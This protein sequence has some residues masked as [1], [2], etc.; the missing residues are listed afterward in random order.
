MA[1]GIWICHYHEW[2]SSEPSD[3]H[4]WAFSCT[5]LQKIVRAGLGGFYPSTEGLRRHNILTWLS[6]CSPPPV[7]PA[8]VANSALMT[9]GL[10][11]GLEEIE[12]RKEERG[13]PLPYK[14]ALTSIRKPNKLTGSP[15]LTLVDSCLGSL[16]E[17][18]TPFMSLP[19]KKFSNSHLNRTIRWTQCSSEVM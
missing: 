16:L 12:A 14:E 15:E 8:V 3:P 18:W 2:L 17:P 1:F 13:G 9:H 4:I 7:L 5:P 11:E 6:S 19:W 10:G